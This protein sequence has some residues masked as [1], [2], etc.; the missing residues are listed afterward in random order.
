MPRLPAA[1]AGLSA[2]TALAP[3][4]AASPHRPPAWLP[5]AA[6]WTLYLPVGLQYTAYLG[7]ALA[8]TAALWR[9]GRL[10]QLHQPLFLALLAFWG[11]QAVSVAWTAAPAPAVVSQL[12]V[13][14]LPLALV[15]IALACAADDASRALRHFVAASTLV[16]ALIAVAAT[17]WLDAW[18][19]ALP[20]LQVRGNQRIAY[21]LLLALGTAFGVLFVLDAVSPRERAAWLACA[22]LCAT[23]LALQDR[24]S[25][26]LVLPL[27]L[28]L[29]ALARTRTWPARVGTV[30]AVALATAVAW[31]PLDGVQ[32]RFAEGFTEL[33][34]YRAADDVATSWGMRVRMAEVT[35]QMVRER[36]LAGFGVGAWLPEWRQRVSGGLLERQTTP[37]NEYLLV[38]AQSGAVGLALLAAAVAAALRT[39]WRC[40]ARAVAAQMVLAT[41][42]TAGL[43][44]VVLRDAKFALP[45]LVLGALT[46]AVAVRGGARVRRFRTPALA[47]SSSRRARSRSARP[48]RPACGP[49]RSRRTGGWPA[50]PAP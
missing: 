49:R 26:M 9:A 39:L 48:A 19:S 23:G 36:P 12:W 24:R 7:L 37:H 46:G 41:L 10:A 1:E 25:G 35:L 40:G 27:L 44:H 6:A 29:L 3:S 21:S 20:P 45:L 8:S 5:V 50:P 15:P 11:W 31:V 33:R 43:F 18:G 34:E 42:V 22:L 32:Q 14:A 17:G 47:R 28:A 13:Y 16:A 2:A 38:A 30:G 4:V